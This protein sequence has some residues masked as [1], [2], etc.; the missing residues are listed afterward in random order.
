MDTQRFPYRQF[1]WSVVAAGALVI[2]GAFAYTRRPYEPTL[3]L[4]GNAV[5]LE[6]M[7]TAEELERGLGGRDPLPPDR[8]M[9]F[10]F[11][12]DDYWPFWMKDMKFS[13]DIIWLDA[14][15]KVV[16]AIK[17]MSPDTYPKVYFPD[18]PARYVIEA[19]AGFV[20]SNHITA[21][22]RLDIR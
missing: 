2:I 16:T 10:V 22:Q 8:A 4:E 18:V 20:E 3:R 7:K 1:V 9:L 14:D 21:G 19:S 12:R 17:N 11:K 6:V 13:I 15:L 5:K